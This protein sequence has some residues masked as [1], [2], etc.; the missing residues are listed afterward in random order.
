M[1]KHFSHIPKL[2]VAGLLGATVLAGCA[3]V[4]RL[5]PFSRKAAPEAAL[6]Y[7]AA[8]AREADG[9]LRVSVRAEGA[10]L[11]AVRESVRYPVTRDCIS[12][13]GSSDA[14]WDI[15]PATG[16][17]AYTADTAGNLTFRARCRG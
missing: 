17:W 16:D 15:D 1:P 4:D 12:R 13:R 6:P 14:D 5:N 9:V 7:R 3:T 8:L 11:D 10:G 2:A